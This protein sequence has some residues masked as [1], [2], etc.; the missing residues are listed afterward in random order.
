MAFVF[1]QSTPIGAYCLIYAGD[2]GVPLSRYHQLV[3]VSLVRRNGAPALTS[4]YPFE[5]LRALTDVSV[6]GNLIENS[7]HN[8]PL[9]V[10]AELEPGGDLL[11]TSSC[12]LFP[13]D[14]GSASQHVNNASTPNL[15]T[16][17]EHHMLVAGPITPPSVTIFPSPTCADP[18]VEHLNEKPDRGGPGLF[19]PT[20]ADHEPRSYIRK[21]L[22]SNEWIS[23]LQVWHKHP[24]NLSDIPFDFYGRLAPSLHSPA[25][26]HSHR[27]RRRIIH[28][29][30]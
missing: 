22:N 30:N 28:V 5:K 20:S 16:P 27:A 19:Q 6:E 14:I 11:D 9:A 4:N 2:R 25:G 29:S 24:V 26:R 15:D 10:N 12:S 13:M 18:F 1:D 21:R 7:I 23:F 3:Q 8:I 17:D